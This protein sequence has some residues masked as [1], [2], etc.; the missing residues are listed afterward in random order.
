MRKNL[1]KALFEYFIYRYLCLLFLYKTYSNMNKNKQAQSTVEQPILQIPA[2]FATMVYDFVSDLTTTFPEFAFLWKRWNNP[3]LAIEDQEELF[4]FFTKVFPERFFDILYQNDDMFQPDSNINTVFLPNVDFKLLYHCGN[5]TENTK[6]AIWKYLQLILISVVGSVKNKASFG[7][8]ANLFE[9]FD[10]K[11][12]HEKLNET[13]D[14]ISNFFK[15]LTPESSGLGASSS[16]NTGE[17][18][19]QNFAQME[20]ELRKVFQGE[21]EGTTSPEMP[22]AEDIHKHLQGLFDGKIGSLAKELAEEISVDMQN[23]FQEDGGVENIQSTQDVLKKMIKNPQKMMGL[24]KTIGDK[25]QTKMKSGDITEEELMKEASELMGKMKGM[26]GGKGGFADIMK[27]MA[28]GMLGKNARFNTTAFSNMEKKMSAKERMRAKLEQKR[29]SNATNTT[30]R[31]PELRSSVGVRVLSGDGLPSKDN[32][33]NIN[34][35]LQ[36]TDAPNNY[37]FSLP[38]ETDQEKTILP[39]TETNEIDYLVNEIESVGTKTNNSNSNKKNKKGGKKH[40]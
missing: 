30:A 28:Q 38:E 26:G 4:L 11:V 14:E 19:T 27:N 23:M 8:A 25:L 33:P 10:E 24:M 31:T 15:N 36:Q 7:D 29:Q 37:V 35:S 39:K 6:K 5:I 40:K 16:S 21:G 17:E 1:Y 20:E 18:S 34:F 9:G 3:N 2:N 12:I 32:Q 22:N 13:I